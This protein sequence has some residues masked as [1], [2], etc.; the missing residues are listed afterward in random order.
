MTTANYVHDG[1]DTVPGGITLRSLT[2]LRAR[3][4]DETKRDSSSAAA[5]SE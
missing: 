4:E 2:R 3:G 5:D 1:A